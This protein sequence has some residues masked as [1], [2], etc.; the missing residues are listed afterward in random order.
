MTTSRRIG[1]SWTNS[2]AS[3]RAILL[4]ASVLGLG[5]SPGFG[6]L[7]G[8]F[9]GFFFW[10]LFSSWQ[11]WVQVIFLAV[12]TLL[13]VGITERAERIARQKA[14]DH[15]VLNLA[16]GVWV[17]FFL[18]WRMD[19]II[20][21]VGFSLFHFIAACRA[22][23]FTLFEGLPGGVGIVSRAYSAGIITNLLLRA[24]LL[25]GIL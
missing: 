6:Y 13:A 10:W 12:F 9:P 8:S 16:I 22:F 21:L 18:L 1:T 24:C 20:F 19:G 14:P 11:L 5:Y 17:S 25:K 3:N 23:P 4:F 2:A 15:I 7:L